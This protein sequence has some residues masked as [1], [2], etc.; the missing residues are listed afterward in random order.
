LGKREILKNTLNK[1]R[2]RKRGELNPLDEKLLK[3]LNINEK[4]LN[5]FIYKEI[6][7]NNDFRLKNSNI[8]N[9][10][11]EFMISISAKLKK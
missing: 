5:Y 2:N 7:I 8:T 1:F 3:L 11:N 9:Q 6:E 4:L 10:D